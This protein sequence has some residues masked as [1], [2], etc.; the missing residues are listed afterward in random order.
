M[1]AS[2][3]CTSTFEPASVLVLE[4]IQNLKR[5][6][7]TPKNVCDFAGVLAASIGG[8]INNLYHK[9]NDLEHSLDKIR[10]KCET[11]KH[12]R[13]KTELRNLQTKAKNFQQYLNETK[14]ELTRSLWENESVVKNLGKIQKEV[15]ECTFALTEIIHE[16]NVMGTFDSLHNYVQGLKS[17]KTN[18]EECKR[19]EEKLFKQLNEI[20]K[21]SSLLKTSLRNKIYDMNHNLSD[22]TEAITFLRSGTEVRFYEESLSANLQAS[23]EL[24]RKKELVIQN[25]ISKLVRVSVTIHFDLFLW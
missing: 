1:S 2:K 20:K 7:V 19:E 17:E 5:F 3:E 22:V 21:E 6:Q 12:L 8:K 11:V 4:C 24:Q 25:E 16:I 23:F 14:K 13:N 18:Y 15:Q 9:K 10:V